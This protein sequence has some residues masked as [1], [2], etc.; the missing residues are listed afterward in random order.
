MI[1]VG[2]DGGAVFTAVLPGCIVAEDTSMPVDPTAALL[3]L[4]QPRTGPSPA[5]WG[6]RG[7]SGTARPASADIA[8]AGIEPGSQELVR[9]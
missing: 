6:T 7:A 4:A 9:S 1:S 8:G 3:P 5:H 2:R